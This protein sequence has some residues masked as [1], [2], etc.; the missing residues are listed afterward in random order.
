MP[1]SLG[2]WYQVQAEQHEP[3]LGVIDEPRLVPDATESWEVVSGEADQQLLRVA[4]APRL[5]ASPLVLADDVISLLDCSMERIVILR[6][7][8]T[9]LTI[10]VC[11]VSDHF[12][13]ASFNSRVHVFR[14]SCKHP[15]EVIHLLRHRG[16]PCRM[17]RSPR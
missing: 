11:R 16:A 14:G 8:F 15:R 17:T 1:L 12:V 6:C 2:R 10:T 3:R 13:P 9:C 5:D 4:L 7:K